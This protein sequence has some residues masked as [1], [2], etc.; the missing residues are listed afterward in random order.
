MT[1]RLRQTLKVKK[2]REDNSSENED[3]TEKADNYEERG[4]IK[5]AR[6]KN[7]KCC[8]SIETKDTKEQRRHV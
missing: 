1:E 3:N 4:H 8:M 6:L 2:L 7:R 5:N